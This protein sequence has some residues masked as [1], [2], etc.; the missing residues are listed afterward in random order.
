M[1]LSLLGCGTVSSHLY[2]TH[3]HEHMHAHTESYRSCRSYYMSPCALY[4]RKHSQTVA[5]FYVLS[6][7]PY[8]STHMYWNPHRTQ[9]HHLPPNLR[10]NKTHRL[11]STSD[12]VPVTLGECCQWLLLRFLRGGLEGG[13]KNAWPGITQLS[14]PYPSIR[15]ADEWEKSFSLCW[16]MAA[17]FAGTHK[18]IY[19]EPSHWIPTNT[20][21]NTSCLYFLDCVK[22]QFLVFVQKAISRV[23]VF[24]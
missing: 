16:Q 2:S 7:T 19:N 18:F 4:T 15:P 21:L 6:L 11:S 14:S 3:S 9:E 5:P 13:W 1:L 12:F 20:I 23:S 17:E 8:Y 22:M 24:Y 10:T